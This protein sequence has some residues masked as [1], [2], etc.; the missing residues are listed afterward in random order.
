[1]VVSPSAQ[2]VPCIVGC[3]DNQDQTRKE[4]GKGMCSVIIATEGGWFSG[5]CGAAG[6]SLS[7]SAATVGASAC[8]PEGPWRDVTAVPTLVAVEAKPERSLWAL[9]RSAGFRSYVLP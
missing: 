7:G 9:L 4:I 3:G 8:V 5:C 1:M 2:G 6:P